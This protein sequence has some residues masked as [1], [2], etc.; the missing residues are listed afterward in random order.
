MWDS[1]RRREKP[2]GPVR[3]QAAAKPAGACRH[4]CRHPCAHGLV[5]MRFLRA[6]RLCARL[7]DPRVVPLLREF[8]YRYVGE[9]LK[10]SQVWA[11]YR[12][13]SPPNSRSVLR[14]CSLNPKP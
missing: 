9:V 12:L 13:N 6:V 10:E 1:D 7:A 4:P 14:V 5:L 8:M 11:E 2:P 3:V